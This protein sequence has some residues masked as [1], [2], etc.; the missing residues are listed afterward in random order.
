MNLCYISSTFGQICRKQILLT[1]KRILSSI[2]YNIS[3]FTYLLIPVEQ[4]RAY[5]EE[6]YFDLYF[7]IL[8]F[9][10][11]KISVL[12]DAFITFNFT[13]CLIKK[14]LEN[15]LY[16]R[17]YV[18]WIHR[19]WLVLFFDYSFKPWHRTVETV[20]IANNSHG[21]MD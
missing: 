1:Q 3:N 18:F 9:Y 10:L 5:G 17:L 12:I 21:L 6:D 2:I 11:P 8:K 20:I 15:L 4:R 13:D 14:Q 19:Y 16:R 7:I